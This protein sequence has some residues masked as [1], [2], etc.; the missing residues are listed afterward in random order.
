MY[1][2]NDQRF[3][4][5]ISFSKNIKGVH[6]IMLVTNCSALQAFKSNLKLHKLRNNAQIT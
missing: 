3:R 4:R 2:F 5:V 1:N 6:E